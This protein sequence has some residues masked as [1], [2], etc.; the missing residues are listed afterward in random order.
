MVK[1]KHPH[2]AICAQVAS[3]ASPHWGRAT[4]SSSLVCPSL[5][6]NHFLNPL[7]FDDR[8]LVEINLASIFLMARARRITSLRICIIP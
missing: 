8:Y 4:D 1:L 3:C 2:R 5:S 6:L 7:G